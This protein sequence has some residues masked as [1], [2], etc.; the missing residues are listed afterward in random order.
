MWWFYIKCTKQSVVG[1][2]VYFIKLEQVARQFEDQKLYIDRHNTMVKTE[3]E[4]KKWK[5]GKQ[6]TT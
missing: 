6:N 5:N 4:V 3:K 1:F 2:W